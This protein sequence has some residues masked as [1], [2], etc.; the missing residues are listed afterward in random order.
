MGEGGRF[1]VYYVLRIFLYFKLRKKL[2][3]FSFFHFTLLK[4]HIVV[5]CLHLFTHVS[6]VT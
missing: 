4:S 5:F 3:T 2:S 1:T 6:F